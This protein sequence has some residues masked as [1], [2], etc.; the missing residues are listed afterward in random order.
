MESFGE[1]LT[2]IL[3]LGIGAT[4]V[5]DVW[6]LARKPLLGISP[7]NYCLV[8]RW[9]GHMTMGRFQ[10][11]SIRE[12]Q[13]V[14]G[15]CIVGWAAHYFIGVG[16]AAILIVVWGL[17]WID[18]PTLAPA[19]VLGMVTLAGPFLIMQPGMGAGIAS[20]KAPKPSSARVQSALTHL[21]FGIGLYLTGLIIHSL[22]G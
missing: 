22:N 5:M 16:F 21:T 10:H 18:R 13:P 19:I 4:A 20:A 8:G 14:R 7:P 6:G 1:H 3:A 15:E 12:S 17:S 11:Q 2:V 9:F